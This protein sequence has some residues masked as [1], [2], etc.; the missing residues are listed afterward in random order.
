MPTRRRLAYRLLRGALLMVAGWLVAMVAVVIALRWLDPPTSAFMLRD[1]IG[2]M[3]S[4]DPR[5]EFRHEWC[6][7]N[8][9]SGH[10]AVAVIAAE[11]QAFAR[12]NGFDFVQI[13]RALAEHANGRRVRGASTISQQVAKNLFLWPGRS[14]L[15]KGLEVGLTLLIEFTWPKQRILEV[16]LNV[17]EFGRGT[18]GVEA[19]SRRYFH[20]SAARLNRPEAA[21]LAAVLPNPVRLRVDA[22]SPYVHRRQ[23]WILGQMAALGGPAAL[24][25]LDD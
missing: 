10:A 7:W 12:H 9:I 3:V 21:L 8:E 25:G 16:Y 1:R 24:N 14:W 5:Y 4:G 17:A 13:D 19:A 20:R 18:W 15:R 11:D 23:Q 2:A 22:P 6:E